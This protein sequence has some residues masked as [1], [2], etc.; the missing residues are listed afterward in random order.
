MDMEIIGVKIGN[1]FHLLKI[2]RMII[3][4]LHWGSNLG[5]QFRVH[6]RIFFSLSKG[7]NK[8]GSYA[9]FDIDVK[10]YLLNVTRYIKR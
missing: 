7:Y 9:V 5:S 1:H 3:H 10:D 6:N 8:S 4:R 2:R